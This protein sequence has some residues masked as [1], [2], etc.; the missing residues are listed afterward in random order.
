MR[1]V[2]VIMS[3]KKWTIYLHKNKVNGKVYIGQTCQ[4]VLKR[5]DN[6]KGYIT[7]SKFYNAILKLDVCSTEG[8]RDI[9]DVICIK[10]LFYQLLFN[11]ISVA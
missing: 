6:G 9:S 7:S 4:D 8:F 10:S 2:L 1:G 3:E 5:W 11:E